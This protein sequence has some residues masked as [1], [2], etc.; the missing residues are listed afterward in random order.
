MTDAR[1]PVA[2]PGDDLRADEVRQLIARGKPMRA[3]ALAV[4]LTDTHPGSAWIWIL[5]AD[6]HRALGDAAAECAAL[7]AAL[8]SKPALPFVRRRLAELLATQGK[9]SA[10]TDQLECLAQLEPDDPAPLMQQA[11]IYGELGDAHM[12]T[13]AWTRLM[14]IRPDL[15]AVHHHLHRLHS[16]AGR[17]REAAVHL[18]R[19]L[20]RRPEKK[21]LW[22]RLAALS[23]SAGDLDGAEAALVRLLAL[24]PSNFPAEEQLA[25]V[26]R[27]KLAS[28]APGRVGLAAAARLAVLGNC[29]AYVMA[30]C[31][32]R[33]NPDLQ[34]DVV[35]LF[36]FETADQIER[37]AAMLDEADVVVAQPA[38]LRRLGLPD[39]EGPPG[40]ARQTLLY[41]N[42]LFTGFHPD[43]L[44]A[45]G[46]NTLVGV[47]HSLLILAAYRQ[48][49]PPNRAAELFNAYVYGVLGYFDEY[50]K[51][52]DFLLSRARQIDWDLSA[53]LERWRGRSP[54]VHTPNHPHIHVM[55]CLA[56][57][58]CRRLG[59][60]FDPDAMAPSDP[61]DG[62]WP[63]YP[64][65]GKRL[66][67]EGRLTFVPGPEGAPSFDLDQAIGWF[68]GLYDRRPLK[69]LTSPRVDETISILKAEGIL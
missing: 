37:R 43:V 11:R 67:V 35:G 40:R 25:N 12:E 5:V 20:Q 54:F 14:A 23:E 55:M 1:G 13:Q 27:L 66:G 15:P 65:V 51:A 49:L 36:G 38:S 32:R 29:Q 44:S 9:L 57:H 56:R 7:E 21:K 34:I 26:R 46:I 4:A 30:R 10:A 3:L 62:H 60:D 39:L 6:C 31:L 22:L 64:E 59:I 42:I 61:F 18:R 41:P 69:C 28:T 17:H 16:E 8:K 33:L 50:A 2:R 58:V 53:D 68:Y 48:G 24:A 63:L 45:P 19:V 52:E 47:W